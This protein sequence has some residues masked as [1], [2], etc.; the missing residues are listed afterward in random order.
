MVY[1]ASYLHRATHA[2]GWH[3]GGK[4]THTAM[5]ESHHLDF[6][7]SISK[8]WKSVVR[9]SKAPSVCPAPPVLSAS[10]YSLGRSKVIRAFPHRVS[11]NISQHPSQTVGKQRA[12]NL[13]LPYYHPLFLSISHVSMICGCQVI[14][15]DPGPEVGAFPMLCRKTQV[16]LKP[17]GRL[18]GKTAKALVLE[19]SIRKAS[20]DFSTFTLEPIFNTLPL[21]WQLGSNSTTHLSENWWFNMI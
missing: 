21:P 11:L 15:C 7:T 12:T 1:A 14:Q 2:H 20:K 9:T 3:R 17:S 10:W 6:H 16:P 18:W 5:I 13:P 8:C 19:V 4:H